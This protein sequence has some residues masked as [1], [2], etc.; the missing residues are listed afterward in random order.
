M[1]NGNP[2]AKG[3][4]GHAAVYAIVYG[5]ERPADKPKE[6]GDR[7]AIYDALVKQG[8]DW[9][10]Y[11]APK[12]AG[13]ASGGAVDTQPVA[14]AP[15]AAVKPANFLAKWRDF[16]D[17]YAVDVNVSHARIRGLSDSLVEVFK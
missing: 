13:P 10:S 2:S 5:Y 16:V 14:P 8:A 4:R 3:L 1:V 9:V 17:V 15:A 7:V 6:Y 12:F 11:A